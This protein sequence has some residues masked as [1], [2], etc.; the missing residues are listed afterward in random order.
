MRSG[1]AWESLRRVLRYPGLE[2]LA[3][4][5]KEVVLSYPSY[6]LMYEIPGGVNPWL[7]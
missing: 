4:T 7:R 5:P 3:A 2:S 6:A 1:G